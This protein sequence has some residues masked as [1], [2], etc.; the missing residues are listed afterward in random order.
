MTISFARPNLRLAKPIIERV[1]SLSLQIKR[2]N[3]LQ[4]ANMLIRRF[5]SIL[6]KFRNVVAQKP[7]CPNVIRPETVKARLR[8]SCLWYG[9]SS[10]YIQGTFSWTFQIVPMM[11]HE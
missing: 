1:R 5:E 7:E 9:L 3:D 8:V 4:D 10:V 11:N 2:E 6:M